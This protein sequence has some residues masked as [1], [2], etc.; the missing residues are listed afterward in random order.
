MNKKEWL[1]Y[2]IADNQYVLTDENEKTVKAILKDL[3]EPF[4]N[5]RVMDYTTGELLEELKLEDLY[6]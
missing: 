3:Y 4:M 5:V 6:S 1:I 2:K